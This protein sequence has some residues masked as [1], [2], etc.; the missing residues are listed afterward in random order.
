MEL[1]DDRDTQLNKPYLIRPPYPFNYPW[2]IPVIG[3]QED[4]IQMEM[5]FEY[6]GGS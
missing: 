2:M 4:G 5:N 3:Y 6:T 1:E